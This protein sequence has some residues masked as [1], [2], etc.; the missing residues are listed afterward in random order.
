MS[1]D[2]TTNYRQLNQSFKKALVFHA[3][4]DAG[5]FAEYTYMVNAMLYCLQNRIQFRLYSADAN[6]GCERGWTDYFVA[7][8]PEADEV[9]HHTYN[10]HAIPSWKRLA[11]LSL[12]EKSLRLLKWKLKVS[13]LTA[14]G[15][16]TAARTYGKGTQLTHHVKLD[17]HGHFHIP[18]LG[19]DGHYMHAFNKMADI[20]WHLNAPTAAS[21][22]ALIDEL[23]L[24]ERYIGCQI[25]GG[26]KVTE[27]SLLPP[28]LY[29][30]I[31]RKETDERHVFVLTDDYR[32]FEHLQA[33]YPDIHWYTLCTPEEQ[34][35]VNSS[36]TRTES[37]RKRQQM[38]RF[39]ASM[40]VLL[41]STRF[42]GS[43]TTGPSLFVLK[44]LYPRI[45]LVDCA[46]DRFME[47][48]TLPIP[49]RG[50]LAEEYLAHSLPSH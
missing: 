28:A 42:I 14:Q 3:G 10:T 44:R 36:F 32:I 15:T 50:R 45:R 33:S 17:P 16:R 35:Y 43:I 9:F 27:V 6:F 30:S 26:D 40:Q 1:T 21:C 2:I 48:I 25:R 12:K 29:A 11:A 4:I 13:W 20:T 31:I 41:R 39:L 47:A 24:P 38:T 19:I 22:Q 37:G 8:C 34:G 5:F 46:P 18:Q 23:H 49:E 7:F